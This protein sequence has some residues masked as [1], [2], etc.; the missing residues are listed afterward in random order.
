MNR[1]AGVLLTTVL[2]ASGSPAAAADWLPLTRSQIVNLTVGSA[3]TEAMKIE[4]VDEQTKAGKTRFVAADESVW[5][6]TNSALAMGIL[7]AGRDENIH[8]I[9]IPVFTLGMSAHQEKADRVF[10]LLSDLVSAIFPD[11]P[12]ARNW[13][14]GSMKEAWNANPLAI[15]KT[16]A[17]PNDQI[18]KKTFGGITGATFGV[19]PDIVVYTV[20]A[21]DICIPDIKQGNPFSRMIC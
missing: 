3:N 11:W 21:R 12:E 8:T 7:M 17:D 1:L 16:P 4:L 18:I 14:M 2:I 20:T 13:P 15:K 10:R 9:R 6:A 5:V 19:P